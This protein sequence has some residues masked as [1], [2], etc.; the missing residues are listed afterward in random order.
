MGELLLRFFIGS[1]V[2]FLAFSGCGGR[3]QK[4][5]LVER[6]IDGDTFVLKD[7]IT[8]RLLGIDTPEKERPY[9]EEAAQAA[10]RML[11][12]KKVRLEYDIEI[13][14]R[15]GRLL[16]YVY[17]PDG[18]FVNARLLEMGMAGVYSRAPN[19]KH[20]DAFLTAQRKAREGKAG[21]WGIQIAL[22]DYYVH[23]KRT[24]VFHRPDCPFAQK[25]SKRNLSRLA[26]RG[27]AL[28]KGLSPCRSC[29]P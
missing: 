17:L 29:N 11:E 6:V 27:D 25:I 14:D 9:F 28:D 15:Y 22:A 13:A 26:T 10:R 4:F 3:G 20:A 21:L 7:N 24:A 16:A 1:A 19:V 23:S 2:C 12:G 5:Y 18:T 8:V